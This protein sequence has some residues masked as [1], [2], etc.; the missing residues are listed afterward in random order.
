MARRKNN[1]GKIIILL[2]LIII[3][4]LAGLMWFD[5][6]GVIQAKKI[7]APVYKLFG[8]QVQT[9][10][11]STSSTPL[12]AD[13]D[14]DRF[15]KRLESLD[16]RTE[17]LNKR[18]TEIAQAEALSQQTAQELEDRRIAQ[19]ERE[20]SFNNIVSRYESR[21]TNVETNVANLNNMPP[22]NAVDILV[23]MD[24]QDIIDIL[25]MA[26]E[27][28]QAQG[29]VSLASTWLMMMPPERA[30]QIQRKMLSKPTTTP[31]ESATN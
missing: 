15:L 2:F 6:L 21:Q 12:E 16:V 4:V 19:E 20:Q 14:N 30:A 11:A 28:A 31:T 23:A 3:L 22:Q 27:V 1:I 13:L 7:F 25:R 8:L 26:D 29:G 17:E 18:E 10:Q 9:T 24:D 5:Y